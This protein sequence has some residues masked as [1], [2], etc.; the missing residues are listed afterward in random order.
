MAVAKIKRILQDKDEHQFNGGTIEVPIIVRDEIDRYDEY[1]LDR[2]GRADAISNIPGNSYGA[3]GKAAEENVPDDY[4]WYAH[5]RSPHQRV[6]D[7]WFYGYFDSNKV[8]VRNETSMAH[9]TANYYWIT[10][11]DIL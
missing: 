11:D 2:C 7:I 6:A 10:E 9:R 3:H 4:E 8:L 1:E 5:A